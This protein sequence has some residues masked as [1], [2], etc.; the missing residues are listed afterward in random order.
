M[1]T[2]VDR[3]S[4]TAE[5]IPI[6]TAP[7]LWQQF[8]LEFAITS[9]LGGGNAD[10]VLAHRGFLYTGA[11]YHYIATENSATCR[12]YPERL[13]VHHFKWDCT[14]IERLKLRIARQDQ[15]A[16]STEAQRYLTHLEEH[17]GFDLIELAKLAPMQAVKVQPG[18]ILFR[19]HVLEA[20]TRE[21]L[22]GEWFDLRLT[23]ENCGTERLASYDPHPV[24]LS[25]HWLMPDG[26]VEKFDGKR[27]KLI[28][29]LSPDS[30]AEY[31]AVVQAPSPAGL[32]RLQPALVQ[33]GVQW[34]DDA[35]RTEPISLTVRKRTGCMEK[36]IGNS[37]I[38]FIDIFP[39]DSAAIELGISNGEYLAA[40]IATL[41]PR[42]LHLVGRSPNKDEVLDL[43]KAPGGTRLLTHAGDSL[44]YLQTCRDE[45]FD[46]AYI[47]TFFP[48][49]QAATE[50]AFL[51]RKMK[52]DGIIAGNHWNDN[53]RHEFW[54]FYRAI[55]DFCATHRWDL[56]AVD[57]FHQWA[58][59][60]QE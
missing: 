4:V 55:I 59:R 57:N 9:R 33:E 11:G 6:A 41:H 3:I 18:Q 47:E 7:T 22:A 45:Y 48:Y 12:Y 34:F 46:W 60:A 58:I 24:H 10:K 53:P 27:S 30:A 38:D 14:I 36:R 44:D 20:P 17:N 2:L 21:L 31:R 54:G 29:P 37:R 56:V 1:G 8:P 49:D 15:V 5:L 50:L 32:Y 40:I 42:E 26:S 13:R 16:W 51:K 43:D 19:I 52:P 39:K 25:Y 35:T 28:P 23:I